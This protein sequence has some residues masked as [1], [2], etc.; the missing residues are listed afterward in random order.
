[1]VLILAL[2][3]VSAAYLWDINRAYERVSG[4]STIISSPYGDIEFTE[5][6]SGPDVLV[7]HG[8]GGG[9][10][11][12]EL[13]V[14]AGLGSQFH[15]IAPSRFGYLQ[16]TFHENATFDDQ[17]HAYAYLLD[18]LRI[19]KVAVVAL[20]HG[21]PS[22]LL[23]AALYPE[24]VSSLT[25]ISCGVASS[26]SKDQVQ[27]NQKGD[28]WVT[29]FKYDSIYWAATKLFK[30]Q[31]IELMGADDAVVSSL[32]PGQKELIDRIIDYMNPVS[33]RSGGAAFDNK[34]AMPNERI[35]AIRAPTLVFHA[36]DDSLQLYHNAEFAASTIPHAHL[37][38]FNRGGHLILSVEQSTIRSTMQKHILDHT[39]GQFS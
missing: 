27:A 16:S 34:A 33:L 1:M 30:K 28:M 18:H 9:Y 14:Q 6:G 10:D 21:G 7:V 23:F 26:S 11:Q 8:S 3:L 32:S 36:K 25:L 4:K 38:S 31:L 20:S 5:G 22:A 19:K 13:L 17:A 37:V 24:R 39:R 35:A 29:I 15:W 12:G 2:V